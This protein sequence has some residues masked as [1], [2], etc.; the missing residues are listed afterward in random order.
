MFSILQA[1]GV[2]F[3]SFKLK[4][5][6]SSMVAFA[7]FYPAVYSKGKKNPQNCREAPLRNMK[8]LDA[9]PFYSGL[10]NFKES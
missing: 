10:L 3:P 8:Q 9:E 2:K 1:A 5:K 7:P 4:K 6:N